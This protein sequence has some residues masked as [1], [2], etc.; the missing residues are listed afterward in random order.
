MS[1]CS[2]SL[3][4]I[5]MLRRFLAQ[6][7]A[8]VLRG[9]IA[10]LGVTLLLSSTAV[11]EKRVALV[12]GNGAYT[13]VP[14][15]DNPKNDAAAMEAM[16]RAA[17]F[18]TV[19]RGNDLGVAEMRR[20][21]R[22]FS[23]TAY[24]ADIAV[25][26]YAGHGIEVGGINYLIPTDA[27]LERD[28]DVHDEAVPLDRVSQ[29][30]EPVRRLRFVILDACRDNPFVRSMRRTLATRSVRSG[31]G[32]IDENSLPPNTLVAYAQ[33]AGATAEDGAGFN[34]PYTTALLKHLP[35]PGLDVELALRRVRD[36][37]L[38]AT[39]NRQEPFKY[40]SLGGT[41]VALVAA[42]PLQPV[43]EPKASARVS[44]AAEAW[45]AV[46][47]TMSVAALEA[48]IARFKDSYYTDLARLR[49]EELNKHQ[50]AAAAPPKA[51]P[52]M[53]TEHCQGDAV[54]V[55][56][57]AGWCVKPG[58][59]VDVW[60]RDCD[61]CPEMVVVPAGSFTMGSP[62]DEPERYSDEDQ[63]QVTI[64][65]P[66]AVGR[67]AVTFGEWDACIADG[68]CNGYKPSDDGW[69]R[70]T[71]PVIKVSWDDAKAFAAW[72]SKKTGK[73]YRLL[74]E[75]EREYVTR[76]G[77]TTPFWWGSTIMPKQANYQGNAD[78]YKGGGAKGEYRQKTVSII[79]FEPNFW[80]FY[81]VHGN[82]YEWSEDC[83]NAS[84][85]GNP[86]DGR[87][88]TIGQCS[89]RVVRGGSWDSN[90]RDVRAAHRTWYEAGSRL[91]TV[92][93]RLAR[94]L[95]P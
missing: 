32:E 74:S 73:S 63:V 92:G 54:R 56:I 25:V 38:K 6:G 37:V 49:I 23:D 26:F 77:T 46:K 35:T 15:L 75:S 91:R 19:V 24:D 95:S 48:Y 30:L 3:P 39:R 67:F 33:R 82:V 43:P 64:A 40:G 85:K 66:F 4:A 1:N 44:E 7:D 34:S 68:G 22:D 16:F 61:G 12:I 58:S 94:T 87:A 76:A 8:M 79:S 29:I 45:S 84:N 88:R 50:L 72:L 93:F 69:G 65:N 31:Y 52:P 14:K 57:N 27:V 10:F 78:P 5:V 71:R 70:G 81:N 47:D 86:G 18:D 80:G 20:A 42:K 51:T 62:T 90:P 28:I 17:G 89:K 59:G 13:K 41:E 21:L 36:D 9:V 2:C 11:A 55:G 60:F 53:P 83:W